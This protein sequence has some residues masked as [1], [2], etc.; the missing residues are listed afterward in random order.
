MLQIWRPHFENL[1]GRQCVWFPSHLHAMNITRPN[2]LCTFP[3]GKEILQKPFICLEDICVQEISEGCLRVSFNGSYCVCLCMSEMHKFELNFRR[4][5][6]G[7]SFRR[8]IHLNEI[9]GK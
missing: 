9:V 1:W 6:Y 3:A 2:K 5:V 4:F 7:K 8:N